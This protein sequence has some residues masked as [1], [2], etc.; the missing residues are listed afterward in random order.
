MCFPVNIAN[1]LRTTFY[2]EHLRWLLLNVL[3]KVY[4]LM[5]FAFMS[6]A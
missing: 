3:E 5:S 6:S 1:F 2:V 4:L